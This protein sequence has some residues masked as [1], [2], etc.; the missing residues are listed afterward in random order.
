MST[1]WI[2]FE[3]ALEKDPRVLRMAHG[4][5]NA[6]VTLVTLPIDT[7]VSLVLGGL[8]RLWCYGDTYIRDNDTI[9]VTVEDINQIVGIENFAQFLPTD[10]LMIIDAN[11]VKLPEF[12]AHNGSI[13]RQRAATAA[14]V[15]KFREKAK[16][17]KRTVTP[18][19]TLPVTHETGLDQD[20]DLFPPSVKIDKALALHDSLPKLE[21][22]QWIAFRRERHWPMTKRA[23]QIHL[24]ELA[25]YDTGTQAEMIRRSIGA[26]WQGIFP[27]HGRPNGTSH[28]KSVEPAVPF[29]PTRESLWK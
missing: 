26:N 13:A 5:R 12:H 16:I 21:W 9:Q 2:K 25:K 6:S 29:T 1:G 27:P 28:G 17:K 15:R 14:R 3:K 18:V 4:I 8:A 22:D 20:L 19:T 11:S 10:W 23:L 24:D 7:V